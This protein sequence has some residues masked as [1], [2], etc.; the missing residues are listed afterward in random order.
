MSTRKTPDTW[1]TVKAV[2][3]GRPAADLLAVVRDLYE[4]S[5]ANRRF[6][7][8]RFGARGYE[9]ERHREAIRAALWPDP[10]SKTSKL[11][12]LTGR[13]LI[14]AYEKA[15]GDEA[16]TLDLMLAYVEAGTG[17]A[18]DC[19]FGDDAFFD[20]LT[21]MLA[22]VLERLKTQP[23]ETRSALGPRLVALRDSANGI[24]WGYG[25][26]VGEAVDALLARTR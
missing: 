3:S 13:Q 20:S 7:H 14:R 26:F 8:A 24:G 18:A 5:D 9:L 17:F 21:R 15:T 25:D 10:F 6:L 22:R 2:V 11:S 12:P 16:G 1:A 4:L 19:G 23:A